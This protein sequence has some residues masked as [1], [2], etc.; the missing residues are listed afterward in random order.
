MMLLSG[1]TQKCYLHGNL[2]EFRLV[3]V[4]LPQ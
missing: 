2:T 4:Q 3:R 1:I